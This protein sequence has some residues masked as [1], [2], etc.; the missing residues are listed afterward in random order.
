L[1]TL[2]GCG[3][4]SRTALCTRGR[5]HADLPVVWEK[6]SGVNFAGQQHRIRNATLNM[7]VFGESRPRIHVSGNS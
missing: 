4:K 3:Q 1:V 6:P 2:I 7:P 5:I